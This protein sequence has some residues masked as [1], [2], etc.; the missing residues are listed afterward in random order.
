MTLVY[1]TPG[2]LDGGKYSDDV[3]LPDNKKSSRSEEN[4]GGVESKSPNDAVF[5][6]AVQMKLKQNIIKSKKYQI[7]PCFMIHVAATEN[8]VQNGRKLPP[9]GCKQTVLQNKLLKWIYK[10]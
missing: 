6:K 8:E 5:T 9:R 3:P 7:L 4:E 1:Q 10:P 2:T